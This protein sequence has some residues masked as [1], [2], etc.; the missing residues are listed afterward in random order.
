MTDFESRLSTMLAN[1]AAEAAPIDQL[2]DVLTGTATVQLLPAARRRSRPV[3]S[4]AATVLLG[5]A[6]LA[7]LNRGSHDSVKLGPGSTSFV[8]QYAALT[9]DEF[10]IDV[11]GKRFTSAGAKLDLN[12]NSSETLEVVWTEHDVEMRLNVYFKADGNQWWSDEFRTYNGKAEGEW[13]TFT[14]DFFRN[15]LGTPATGTFDAT[16]TEG[17]V[18]SH[19]H[20]A[21]MRMQAFLDQGPGG[22]T[23]PTSSTVPV[24]VSGKAPPLA[25][26]LP[27]TGKA[28]TPQGNLTVGLASDVLLRE[29]MVSKGWKYPAVS[30]AEFAARLGGAWESGPVLGAIGLG[31][32]TRNGYHFLDLKA[33]DPVD[34]WIR[35]LDRTDQERLSADLSGGDPHLQA[36]D[37]SGAPQQPASDSCVGKMAA[38]LGPA[39]DEQ[40]VLR[41]RVESQLDQEKAQNAAKNDPAVK[42][43]LASWSS[44]LET[45]VGEKALTPSEMM[46][47][48]LGDK[49][50]VLNDREKQIA[51]ADVE[52]QRKVDLWST[53]YTALANRERTLM[54]AAVTT[55][56][57]LVRLRQTLVAT[58]KQVLAER[59]IAVPSLD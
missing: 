5:V 48:Y 18:T 35:G 20:I 33:T 19:I 36:A 30:P 10:W 17:G 43:A 2:D 4:V 1:R 9:A 27:S 50:P 28:W 44:C 37:P 7:V 26:G 29:C 41:Q 16:A 51:A 25:A 52:C 15:S 12:S 31:N 21:G 56:D 14:G 59:N 6:G 39:Y 24:V 54:R 45:A 49:A 58:A 47:R 46:R 11:D 38:Q 40:E 3:F 22:V 42:V 13:V 32:A 8:T 23:V 53:Y 57:E 34:E 55:Y